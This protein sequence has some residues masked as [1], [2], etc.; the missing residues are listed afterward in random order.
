MNKGQLLET[1][2]ETVVFVTVLAPGKGGLQQKAI[3]TASFLNVEQDDFV[4]TY[5]VTCKHVVQEWILKRSM[6]HVRVNRSDISDVAH[7]PLDGEWVFHQDQAVDLAVL[8]V[9]LPFAIP[10]NVIAATKNDMGFPDN[11]RIQLGGEVFYIGLFWQY[12][13]HRRNY[14]AMRFGK[15]SLQTNELIEGEYEESEYLMLECHAHSGF[16]GAPV[17]I[18]AQPLKYIAVVHHRHSRGLLGPK[19]L[20]KN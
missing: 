19:A 17:Y 7:V 5:L 3:G 13:G 6:L 15:L 1:V 11:Y 14:P 18:W 20:A 9:T 10:A 8:P 2:R 16:S 4:Y 12:K